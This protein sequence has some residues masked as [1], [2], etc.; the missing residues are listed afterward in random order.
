MHLMLNLL[1]MTKGGERRFVHGRAWL[2]MDMLCEESKTNAASANYF[3]LVGCFFTAKQPKNSG[4]PSAVATDKTD[5]LTGIN[6][7]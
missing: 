2:K 6:L 3:P 5:M 4:L 7:H 1:Q